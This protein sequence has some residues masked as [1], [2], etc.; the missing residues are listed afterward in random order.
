MK[1]KALA[2][3]M[4]VCMAASLAACG[5]EKGTE[6][7]TGKD[8]AQAAS[9]ESGSKE[10]KSEGSSDY[11]VTVEVFDR[12]N[13]SGD[14]GTVL[15]NRWSNLL[16]D[17]AKEEAGISYDYFA[18][19]RSEEVP[20]LQ[21]LLAAGDEP[22]IF[23]TYDQKAFVNWANSG[24]LADLTDY[25][26]STE[27]GK[28][29]KE[30][31]GEDNIEA[32]KING[33]L[34]ALCGKRN[35]LAFFSGFARKDMLDAV[36]V[37]MD[38]KDGHY[39]MTPSQLKDALNKIKA[40]GLCDY[41]YGF[42][43]D[44]ICTKPIEGAFYKEI[45]YETIDN[46]QGILDGNSFIDEGRKETIRFLNECYN[47][48]LINPDFALLERANLEESVA[49]GTVA[50]YTACSWYYQDKE[51][52][53]GQMEALLAENPDAEYVAVEIVHEDET[54]AYYQTYSPVQAYGMISAD[55][56]DIEAALNL[57]AWFLSSDNAHMYAN[58]GIEGENYTLSESGIPVAI[59]PDYNGKTR[60]NTSDLNMFT[61]SDPCWAG[62]SKE[63]YEKAYTETKNDNRSESVIQCSIDARNIALSEGKYI[64][65]VFNAEF[66]ANIQWGTSI[67][68]NTA[69][70]YV[71]SIM[72][73]KDTFD[74]VYDECYQIYMDEGARELIE[75]K[76]DFLKQQ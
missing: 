33:S 59:D 74:K 39:V 18:I 31:L 14:Y 30:K 41:P 12:G 43:Y 54:S 22:D 1:R 47:D 42:L 37:T 66:E 15:D 34:Y 56:E 23:Y 28:V 57:V 26:E 2:M 53:N 27:A 3:M 10:D 75:E 65:T 64:P 61:V 4:C 29:I 70:L 55:C 73:S 51:G 13:I 6:S 32:G 21:T 71:Q 16:K 62:L 46:L 67:E 69:N 24:Y 7:S 20:K 36:G 49:S 11:T 5:N 48:G 45:P 58:H 50:F 19:P 72:T 40:A 76:I 60:I 63:E 9:T 52:Q 25:I 35:N 68:E 8:N 38:T 44:E 17:T